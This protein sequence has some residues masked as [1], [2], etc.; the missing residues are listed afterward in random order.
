MKTYSSLLPAWTGVL[1]GVRTMTDH[2]L[3]LKTVQSRGHRQRGTIADFIPMP[4]FE[5]PHREVCADGEPETENGNSGMLQVA[6][7]QNENHN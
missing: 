2:D 1:S 5:C 7:G 6:G 4:D 3:H